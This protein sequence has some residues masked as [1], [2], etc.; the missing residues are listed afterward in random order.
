MPGTSAPTAPTVTVTSFHNGGR[1]RDMNGSTP[2]E[3]AQ[4]MDISLEN[5][6]IYVDDVEAKA[7]TPLRAGQIVSFQRSKVTSGGK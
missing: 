4:A 2:S 1:P 6:A 3:L 5:V 7:S